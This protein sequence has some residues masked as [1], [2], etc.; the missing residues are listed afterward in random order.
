MNQIFIILIVVLVGAAGAYWWFFMKNK[1]PGEKKVD[2]TDEGGSMGDG[3]TE[4][5]MDV[6]GEKTDENTSET[7]PSENTST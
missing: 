6:G 4:S 1:E 7:P 3:S 5:S 2:M